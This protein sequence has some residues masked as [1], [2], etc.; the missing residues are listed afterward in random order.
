MEAGEGGL[1]L[2]GLQSVVDDGVEPCDDLRRRA[3]RGH[4]A[5]PGVDGEI[6]IAA[7]DERRHVRQVRPA[8]RPGDGERAKLAGLDLRNEDQH[9]VDGEMR[10]PANEIGH[11]RR[12][13]F[14]GNVGD[15][16]SGLGL[17]Q[18]A[19]EM[20]RRA[21]AGAVVELARVGL[22]VGDELRDRLRRHVGPDHHD[23]R[24]QRRGRDRDEVLERIDVE[25]RIERGR[26]AERAGR[27]EQQRIAVGIGC[28][29]GLEA[30]G[31]ARAGAVLDDHLLA[32]ACRHR[33]AGQPRHG[34]DRPARRERHDHLD[35]LVRI[36][37]GARTCRDAGAERETGGEQRPSA[38]HG[39]LPGD[40]SSAVLRRLR[41]ILVSRRAR[42]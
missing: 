18:G 1:D 13:A 41:A 27:A 21:E 34:V 22:G 30:D 17:E 42:Q 9:A 16:E 24:Q 32:E 4:D 35:R 38:D 2:L 26:D 15:V 12:R 31:G 5:G 33:L 29:C 6:G 25:A 23:V 7:L 11:R 10:L 3:F 20:R 36:G 8:F 40:R 19:Q 37:L 14:V 28:G 39:C